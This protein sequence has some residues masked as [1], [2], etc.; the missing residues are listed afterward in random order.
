MQL[1]RRKIGIPELLIPKLNFKHVKLKSWHDTR[2]RLLEIFINQAYL[3]FQT[4]RA[5]TVGRQARSSPRYKKIKSDT[6]ISTTCKISTHISKKNQLRLTFALD[7][8][9]SNLSKMWS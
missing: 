4:T 7:A 6:H 9:R 2:G 5:D 1:S 3:W 8:H